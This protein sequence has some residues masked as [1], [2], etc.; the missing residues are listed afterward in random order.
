MFYNL[1]NKKIR[2][3]FRICI[4]DRCHISSAVIF[5]D[6]TNYFFAQIFCCYNV[7]MRNSVKLKHGRG[8]LKFPD[9]SL[10]SHYFNIIHF[11]IQ[12]NNN[13]I[14]TVHDMIKYGEMFYFGPKLLLGA[15][16][17]L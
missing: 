2:L 6:L 13:N 1:S 15:K 3:K 7:S 10:K 9:L 16:K 11:C 5:I 8:G 17:K 14:Q 12:D 4:Y